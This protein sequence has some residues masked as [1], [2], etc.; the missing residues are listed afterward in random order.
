M[1]PIY[2]IS[3]PVQIC[4]AGSTLQITET[5]NMTSE[6]SASAVDLRGQVALVTGASSGLGRRFA[7]VLSA[8]G[9]AV[10]LAGR[11]ID[12]LNRLEAEIRERGGTAFAIALDARDPT[13]I[14]SSIATIES[15]LGLITIL[16]NNAATMNNQAATAIGLEE[17]NNLIDTN[18]RGPFLLCA[19]VARRLIENKSPGRVVNISSVN[20]YRQTIDATVALYSA[21]KSAVLRLTE[22]LAVEWASHG[23]NVNAIAPGLFRTEMSEKY[24]QEHEPEIIQPFPRKRVGEP[25]QLD[26]TLLY[27]LSPASEFVT[28]ICI[29]V[30]DAQY[31]R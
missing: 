17:I 5:G 11:R 9:A 4:G 2:I 1:T 7:E 27:L 16:V 28:G 6:Q 30:D 10:A 22:T 29:L 14:R 12:R 24:M 18:I 23:I 20:A 13:A 19:E 31:S 15:K 21:T 8:C 26:S 25:W 3:I